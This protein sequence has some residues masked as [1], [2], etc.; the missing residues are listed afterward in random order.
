MRIVLTGLL[1][2][3][4]LGAAINPGWCPEPADLSDP[5]ELVLR[6][7]TLSVELETAITPGFEAL[8]FK[9]AHGIE[10]I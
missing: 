8:V 4:V 9:A 2:T 3:F 7:K 5:N 1:S 6:A 10:D